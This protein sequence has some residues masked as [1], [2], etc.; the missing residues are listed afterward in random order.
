MM[1][2]LQDLNRPIGLAPLVQYHEAIHVNTTYTSQVILLWVS[3]P[4]ILMNV[5]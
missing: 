1:Y 2:D 4:W 3:N 5:F